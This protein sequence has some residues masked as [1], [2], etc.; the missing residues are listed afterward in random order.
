MKTVRECEARIVHKNHNWRTT[1]VCAI[2]TEIVG[3]RLQLSE[4]FICQG[5][6]RQQCGQKATHYVESRPSTDSLSRV[7]WTYPHLKRETRTYSAR[8]KDRSKD[9][10]RC[11]V[12]WSQLDLQ[13]QLIHVANTRLF[14]V[15]LLSIFLFFCSFSAHFIFR[16]A[17]LFETLVPGTTARTVCLEKLNTTWNGCSELSEQRGH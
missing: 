6:G 9:A 16:L 17:L 7:S 5:E 11:Q 12:V 1:F 8:L 4:P 10:L 13:W 2:N 3:P 15:L 14:T